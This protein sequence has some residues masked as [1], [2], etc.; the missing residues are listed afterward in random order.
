VLSLSTFLSVASCATAHRNPSDPDNN[1]IEYQFIDA[2]TMKPIQ[3]AY[4]NVVWVSPVL[5]GK[6]NGSHCMQAALLRSDANGWVKMDGPKG[7]ILEVPWI[8]VPDYE[9]FRYFYEEPDKEHILHVIRAGRPELDGYPAWVQKLTNIGYVYYADYEHAYPGFY[10][11]FPIKRFVDN[12]SR[13]GAPQQY[14]FR[15]RSFPGGEYLTNVGH[16][17]GPEGI[18]IGL[19]EAER[20]EAD[21]RRGLQ[22]LKLICDERWDTNKGSYPSNSLPQALWLVEAPLENSKA[23]NRLKDV[24]PNYQGRID[25]PIKM[26]KAER[27]AFCA[28]MQPFAGGHK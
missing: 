6:V 11:A 15:D 21:I 7:S 14:Y 25:Y 23:W 5:P 20:S 19:G 13:H 18:N 4:V 8:M 28:W 10:K 27:I 2:D 24:I 9:Y 17:C 26:S 22:Q 12:T 16:A 3:G 1:R